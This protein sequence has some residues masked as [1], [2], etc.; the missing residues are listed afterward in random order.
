MLREGKTETD[1][2]DL[3]RHGLHNTGSIHWNLSTAALYEA[4]VQHR[5]GLLAHLGPIV[6]NTGEHTGRS[7]NDKFFVQEPSSADQIWWGEVNRPMAPEPFERLKQRFFSYLQGKELF[8]QD[9]FAGADPAY[10]IAL[11][12]ITERAWHSLFARN[13]F[14]TAQPSEEE[15]YIPEYTIIHAPDFHADPQADTTHSETFVVL[16]FAQKLVLIGGTA[17]AGEIK[18]SVF[19]LLNY[20]LPQERVLSMHCSANEGADNDIAL[21]FGLSGTGKTTLSTD[22]YRRLIGDD[23]HGWST[24][25]VFN[26]E[27]GCYAKVI[28]L[29]SVSEPEIYAC[30]RRFGTVLENVVLDPQT[31]RLDLDDAIYTE[32]TRAAY[33]I[34]HLDSYVPSG[35][36]GH[37]QNIFMLTCDAFGILPPIARLT[38][39]QAMYYFISGY[40]AKVAGTERG[41]GDAPEATFSPCFGAPFMALH[42]NT[43]ADLLRE[44]MTQH[45]A[46]CWLVNT[47][48]SGGPYGVGQRMPIA[49]TRALINAALDGSLKHAPMVE[50]SVFG[51]EIPTKCPGVPETIL[52]PRNTWSDPSAYDAQAHQLAHSFKDHLRRLGDGLDAEVLAAGP[53]TH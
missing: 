36:G 42:P 3:T 45:Q 18:K 48:W 19:T 20:L 6:I 12:V 35:I 41:L 25:G 13:L 47:G 15:T 14:I 2:K 38:P 26:I 53:R 7:P 31:R 23:E 51:I 10:R 37:P 39:D 8:V 33:P 4:I 17:Y 50:D 1:I 40:T 27:G 29:S 11:R 21:F 46:T 30:T 34:T 32:N 9:C 43:Y 5:E 44:R 52:Q 22:P 16:H 28:R 49:H 24:D